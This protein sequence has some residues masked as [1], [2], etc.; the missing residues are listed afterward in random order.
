MKYDNEV[1]PFEVAIVSCYEVCRVF[2]I[3]NNLTGTHSLGI[4]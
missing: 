3:G 2:C 4:V 1:V